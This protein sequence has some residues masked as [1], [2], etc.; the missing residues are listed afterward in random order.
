MPARV[1]ALSFV[2]DFRHGAPLL[3]PILAFFR[4]AIE[5]WS[6]APECPDAPNA[7]RLASTEV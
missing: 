5:S 7:D 1:I 3:K 4:P 6:R 2:A